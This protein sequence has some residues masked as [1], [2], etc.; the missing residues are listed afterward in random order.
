MKVK[1]L[2]TLALAGALLIGG[3]I[4]ANAAE[5]DIAWYAARNP[6]VVAALGN[7]PE[8]LRKHYEMHGR[9]EGRMA[10]SHDVEG[11]LRKL[12][13]AR[14]YAAFYPDV[15]A[16]FGDDEE[17]MFRHY[18]S[19]GLLETRR[20]CAKVSYQAA[21]SLKETVAKAMA[22]AGLDA[23]PGSSQIV[24]IM[25]GSVPNA[26]GGTAVR[27]AMIQVAAVVEKVIVKTVEEANTPVSTPSSSSSSSSGSDTGNSGSDAEEEFNSTDIIWV[28]LPGDLASLT[29]TPELSIDEGGVPKVLT[30]FNVSDG[31]TVS[32]PEYANSALSGQTGN[33]VGIGV[34]Y[35]GEGYIYHVG[36]CDGNNVIVDNGDL[37]SM[38][39]PHSVSEKYAVFYWDLSQ[40]TAPGIDAALVVYKNGTG[41]SDLKG[42]YK[43]DFSKFVA[44]DENPGTD[45]NN[46][47][48]DDNNEETGD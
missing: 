39:S 24:T 31:E 42:M 7:S 22:E 48:T 30:A 19:Y 3:V 12:F 18:I 6:D 2:F 14:E 47:G 29:V 8:A 16:A 27:Q 23:T 32:I 4:T 1:K 33:W 11:Q 10:N 43:I 45:D 35:L 28:P 21:V 17:A 34:P 26:S 44:A 9:K 46:E 13:D 37:T 41:A 36:W 5:V 40:R 38:N 15:K 20:P 25:E